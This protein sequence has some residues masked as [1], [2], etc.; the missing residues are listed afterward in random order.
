M[1]R[2]YDYLGGEDLVK[3]ISHEVRDGWVS[4]GEYIEKFE[5]E[6]SKVTGLEYNFSVSNGTIALQCAFEALNLK[7]NDEIVF[8][9]LGYMA[10]ANVAILKGYKPL[11]ADVNLQTGNLDIDSLRK[12]ITKNTKAVVFI[13]NYGNSSG[14]FEIS[15]FCISQS[16]FLVED[17][18][19]GIFSKYNGKHIGSYGD[20]ATF[21]FHAAK[22]ITSGEGGAIFTNN[23]DL[24]KRITLL[25]DHGV[26]RTK[27]NPYF[28]STQGSNFRMSNIHA[29]IGYHSFLNSKTILESKKRVYKYY[30]DNI[31]NANF[32]FEE[33]KSENMYWAFPILCK[34]SISKKQLI[35]SFE[36]NN[37]EV[38]DCFVPVNLMS[39]YKTYT[40]ITTNSNK[41]YDRLLFLPSHHLLTD[42]CTR[43][44]VEIIN[45]I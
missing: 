38:R 20:I 45:S 36:K 40:Q 13:H 44:I 37:I 18:A 29:C 39:T 15:E 24:A 42:I 19:E 27:G 22:T 10:A 32:C 3:S 34:N 7:P 2:F 23:P 9:S 17:C 41:I 28:H 11:F 21:S 6:I 33:K 31:K 4:K 12:I 8:P 25:K 14:I 16:L 30:Y 26:D 5:N 35:L 43:K 1:I